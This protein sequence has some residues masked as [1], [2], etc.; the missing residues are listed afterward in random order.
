MHAFIDQHTIIVSDGGMTIMVAAQDPAFSQVREY[1]EADGD[2]ERDFDTVRSIVYMS[3]HLVDAF[4]WSPR[5]E[6]GHGSASIGV[7]WN[8]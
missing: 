7:P 3:R 1:L 6:L 4:G 5:A 2:G 8:Q